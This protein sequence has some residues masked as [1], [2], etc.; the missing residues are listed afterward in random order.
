MAKART[1]VATAMIKRFV[2][3]GMLESLTRLA[4]K[5][6]ILKKSATIFFLRMGGMTKADD[7]PWR[8]LTGNAQYE[9][10]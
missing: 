8:F 1:M 3:R 7:S 9:P 6:T 5:K 10:W 2:M 4:M